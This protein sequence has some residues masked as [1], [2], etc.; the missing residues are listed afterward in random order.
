MDETI[1]YFCRE[2]S[3]FLFF[4]LSF[5]LLH[6]LPSTLLP[7]LLRSPF[8]SSPRSPSLSA[9]FF[10]P[11][12][13]PLCSILLPTLLHS[14]HPPLLPALLHSLL[15]SSPHSPSLSTPSPSPFSLPIPHFFLAS[16]PCSF[17]HPHFPFHPP[18]PS[19][20]LVPLLCTLLL[21]LPSLFFLSFSSPLSSFFSSRFPT[22]L[23]STFFPFPLIP[24]SSPMHDM[25]CL[26]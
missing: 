12:S 7:A 8:Y 26:P 23:F 1:K 4:S 10:S 21:L 3:N 24:L 14:P 5:P 6:S 9:L 19:I 18:T 17:L 13:F 15:Y 20:P 2:G 16:L 25:S 22:V 11:L